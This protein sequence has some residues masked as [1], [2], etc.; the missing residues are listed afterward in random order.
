[1]GTAPS[2]FKD[3]SQD[4][5][6]FGYLKVA[7]HSRCATSLG[8]SIHQIVFIKYFKKSHM[9]TTSKNILQ[10]LIWVNQSSYCSAIQWPKGVQLHC[11]SI[12]WSSI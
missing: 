1:M 10:L 7:I 12:P 8:D 5:Y 2:S 11:N 9:N 3:I 4:V 6:S